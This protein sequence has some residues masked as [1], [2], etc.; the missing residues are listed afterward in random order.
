MTIIN[1]TFD[2]VFPHAWPGC[3]VTLALYFLI[4]GFAELGTERRAFVLYSGAT[5]RVTMAPPLSFLSSGLVF[6]L[7]E[8]FSMVAL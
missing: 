1:A 6:L 5:S 3:W 4:F 8:V 7:T 2:S